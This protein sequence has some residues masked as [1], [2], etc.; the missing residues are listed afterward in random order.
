M[1]FG[2]AFE[3]VTGESRIQFPFMFLNCIVVKDGFCELFA[4][5]FLTIYIHFVQ[6]FAT[7][8][9][10]PMYQPQNQKPVKVSN[11]LGTDAKIDATLQQKTGLFPIGIYPSNKNYSTFSHK[12]MA[13]YAGSQLIKTLTVELINL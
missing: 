1:A 7:L 8:C 11:G 2:G 10:A 12:I 6:F 5:V 9:S 3:Y 4:N 13:I